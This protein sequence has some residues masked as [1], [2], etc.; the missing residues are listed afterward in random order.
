MLARALH[1]VVPVVV[2]ERRAA[3]DDGR[4]IRGLVGVEV[5]VA[6]V[7]EQDHARVAR[8]RTARYATRQPVGVRRS[9]TSVGSV[10]RA[11]ARRG[12]TR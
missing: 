4:G 8:R 3:D 2:Q 1:V 12:T 7:L 5:A 6:A 10:A 9:T 11:R